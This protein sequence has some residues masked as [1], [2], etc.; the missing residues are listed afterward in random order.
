MLHT[1]PRTFA[2]PERRGER[3]AAPVVPLT[4]AA[5]LRLRRETAGLSIAAVA[6]AVAKRH[7]TESPRL[8]LDL[9]TA[10]IASLE[11]PGTKARHRET[12]DALRAVFAFDPDVYRQ[13][14]DEPADRHPRVCRG[15]GCSRW[16]ACDEDGQ[17]CA[18]AT[19]TACTRCLAADAA[20][21]AAQDAR[22]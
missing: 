8:P 6:G 19:S 21:A 1:F 12:L 18:W 14:A 2:L 10:L 20:D 17:G 4:P 22:S 16:D 9:T 5:Y 15:C 11:S 7:R 13:L 3:A